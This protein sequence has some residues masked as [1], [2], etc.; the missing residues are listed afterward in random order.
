MTEKNPKPEGY[1]FGRPTDYTPEL[2]KRICDVV[3]THTFGLKRLCAMFD[4]MP[5]PTTIHQWRWQLEDFSNLYTKAKI[6]QAELLAEDCLDIADETGN[7]ITI[8]K[9]GDEVCNSEFVNRS[10]LRVD[11]RKWL[12]AKLLPK[13]YGDMQK[14]S[15]SDGNKELKEEMRAIREQLDS[16]NQKEF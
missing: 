9:N 5:A 1:T 15:E 14:T 13:I 4:W 11:T 8:N 3:S 7:D 12:T 16:K 2:G 6:L 10:R